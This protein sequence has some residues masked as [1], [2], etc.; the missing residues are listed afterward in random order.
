MKSFSRIALAVGVIALWSGTNASWAQAPS[1]LDP[2][3]Q[4]QM[5][6]PQPMPAEIQQGQTP[7]PS[8][9]VPSATPGQPAAPAAVPLPQSAAP[10]PTPTPIVIETK[11]DLTTDNPGPQDPRAARAEAVAGLAFTKSECRREASREAQQ[12]CLKQAQDDYN[13]L[14][15]QG[16]RSRR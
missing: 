8:A 10:A 14:M 15:S 4:S 13:A 7:L 1:Q 16:S 2:Q 6:V 3:V 11:V 9:D 5:P 12:Q